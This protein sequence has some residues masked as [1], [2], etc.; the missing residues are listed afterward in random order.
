MW[1]IIFLTNEI[2][3]KFMSTIFRKNKGT[4]KGFFFFFSTI[5]GKMIND[6]KVII[7]D[8]VNIIIT[9]LL[10]IQLYIYNLNIHL[11]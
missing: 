10:I 1:I 3:S 11:D 9:N 4:R 2:L 8:L 7:K 5:L 6:F